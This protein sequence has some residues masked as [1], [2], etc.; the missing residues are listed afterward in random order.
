MQ[1]QDVMEMLGHNNPHISLS[2]KRKNI[3]T[4]RAKLQTGGLARFS[5]RGRA[6]PNAQGASRS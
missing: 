5:R 4:L 3:D 1:V 6:T 2:Y